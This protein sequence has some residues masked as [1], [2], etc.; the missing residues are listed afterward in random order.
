MRL[1][2]GGAEEVELEFGQGGGGEV[3]VDLVQGMSIIFGE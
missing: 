1:V 3:E 2:S